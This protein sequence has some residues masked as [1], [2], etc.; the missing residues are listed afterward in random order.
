MM[1]GCSD[2][3][4][5]APPLESGPCVGACPTGSSAGSHLVINV[6]DPQRDHTGP[7]DVTRMTMRIYGG[8][9]YEIELIADDDAPFNG[10]FRVNMNLFNVNAGKL[11]KDVFNES[12]L[13]FPQER[14]VLRGTS[15][16]LAR[17]TPGDTVYTNSLAGT[18]N[19]PGASLFRSSVSSAPHGFLT[20]EDFIADGDRSIPAIVSVG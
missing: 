6:D 5:V 1:P 16:M 18:P 3:D 9:E 13:M 10:A 11:F 20:N 4:V 15:P 12:V 17:W 2:K 8:G 19:P 14:I 7:I